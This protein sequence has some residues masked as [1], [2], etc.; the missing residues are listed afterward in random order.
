MWLWGF[1]TPGGFKKNI[2]RLFRIIIK[3]QIFVDDSNKTKG[4]LQNHLYSIQDPLRKKRGSYLWKDRHLV[5]C[6]CAIRGGGRE[7]D[8]EEMKFFP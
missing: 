2:I 1:E 5:W 6:G 7:V 3:P 8:V 4:L